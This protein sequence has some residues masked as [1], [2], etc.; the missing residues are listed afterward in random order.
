M[1]SWGIRHFCLSERPRFYRLAYRHR[2]TSS[3]RASTSATPAVARSASPGDSSIRYPQASTAP[4]LGRSRCRVRGAVVDRSFQ[5][6]TTHRPRNVPSSMFGCLFFPVVWASEP[7]R[8][9]D[10]TTDFFTQKPSHSTPRP[11]TRQTPQAYPSE[12]HVRKMRALP[13]R[14]TATGIEWFE[15]GVTFRIKPGT[16]PAFSKPS[17][18]S[19]LNPP[20]YRPRPGRR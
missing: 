4:W 8:S 12:P 9:G 1:E 5:P 15:L 2:T 6:P 7:A 20:D 17:R 18:L 11:A 14:V 19:V 3:V 10:E 13:E 16:V